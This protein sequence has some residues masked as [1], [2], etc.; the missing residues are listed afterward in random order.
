MNPASRVAVY[1]AIF[2]ASDRLHDPLVHPAGADF[3]CFTDQPLRSRVWQVRKVEPPV[4]GDMTRSNRYYKILAHRVIPGYE[5][6]VYVDGNVQI[7]GDVTDLMATYLVGANLA[8]L[9]HRRWKALPLTSLR[10][11]LRELVKMEQSGKHQE[12]ADLMS[13]QAEA[14][15][16]EGFPDTG[17]LSWNM[18]LLR[19]HNEPDVVKAMEAWWGELLRWSKR[20]QVS[21]NYVAWKTG[22]AFNYIPIDGMDNPYV[23]R[24]NHRLTSLQQLHSYALGAG[25]RFGRFFGTI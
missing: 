2:G 24:L 15:F 21:F 22:L 19:R 4:S 23:K 8:V 7:T 6:S 14:Y 18:M 11:E 17:G 3:I 13:R 16:K 12:D 25:K 9:D 20:D 1:T 5:T 10:E